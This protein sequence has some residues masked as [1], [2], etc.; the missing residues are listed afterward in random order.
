MALRGLKTNNLRQSKSGP[1]ARFLG[2]LG[3]F[4]AS[5]ATPLRPRIAAELYRLLAIGY[6]LFIRARGENEPF[7]PKARMNL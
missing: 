1:L 7:E 2:T 3:C 5:Q 6:W 4:R